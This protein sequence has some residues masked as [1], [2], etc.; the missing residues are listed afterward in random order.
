MTIRKAK[1]EDKEELIRLYLE[2]NESTKKTLPE[3]QNKF[4]EFKNISKYSE[5]KIKRYLSNP[6]YIVFVADDTGVL[7]GYIGGKINEAKERVNDKEGY[8]ENWYVEEEYQSKGIG[9]KLFD[10]LVEEFKK[11]NCTHIGLDTH[12]EY[13]NTIAIYKHLGFTKRL[14]TFFKLI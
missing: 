2:F 12:L 10:K 7:I 1:Q 11:L 5:V 3:N 8:I 6:N 14:I 13:S 4:R 9:K